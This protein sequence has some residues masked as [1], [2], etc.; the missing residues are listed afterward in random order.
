MS[1]SNIYAQSDFVI[2]LEFFPPR[3]QE[4]IDVTKSLIK[5][6][7]QINPAFMTV[8]YGAGGGTRD[9]TKDLVSYI[10]NQLKAQAVSHL[11]CVGHSVE[12]ID[13]VL[14]GLV[15]EGVKYVLALRGDPP[16]GEKSFVKHPNGF[17]NAGELVRHIK[18]RG[19]FSIAVAGYP[20]GHLE[21]ASL[22][23]DLYYLKEKVDAGAEVVFTQLFFDNEFYFR[24]VDQ[25]QSIGIDV[26]IVP[27]IMPISNAS[28]VKRFTE[29]CGASLPTTLISSLAKY[30]NS[31]EDMIKFGIDYALAQCEN[32]RENKAPGLHLYTLNKTNQI[33]PILKR[34]GVS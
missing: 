6:L 14:D 34:L 13:L 4:D 26:P 16:K 30:E 11:T 2:S 5:E 32:L 29:M 25:A 7:S 19:D 24:F 27:G 8:T 28:Q 23:Q 9:L 18:S 17:A 31:Q 3:K 15:K 20:E 12:E 1:F 22:E 21:A 33:V 10:H